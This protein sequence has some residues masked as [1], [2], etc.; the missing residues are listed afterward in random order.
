MRN[1]WAKMREKIEMGI[2]KPKSSQAFGGPFAQGEGGIEE[3]VQCLPLWG[4]GQS[5]CLALWVITRHPGLKH[6]RATPQELG[7]T[8]NKP[9]A[10]VSFP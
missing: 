6:Q 10:G 5:R 2:Q 1:K 8:E 7:R 3:T 4:L 9:V